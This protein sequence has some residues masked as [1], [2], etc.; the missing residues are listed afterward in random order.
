VASD[1]VGAIRVA[2]GAVGARADEVVEA[3]LAGES[4]PAA[5]DRLRAAVRELEGAVVAAAL[6]E[7]A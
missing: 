6:R 5:L 2:A 3:W 1:R 7:R 4:W